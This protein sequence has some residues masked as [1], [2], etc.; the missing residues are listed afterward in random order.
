VIAGVLLAAGSGRRYGRPKALVDTGGGPWVLRALDAMALCDSLLVVVGA[1]ADEVIALLPDGVS[2]VRNADHGGG[3]GSSLRVGL[4]A[5]PQAAD[6]ALVMLVDLPDVGAPVIDR[7]LG[8]ARA[9]DELP[10]LLYRAAYRGEPGHPVLLGRTHF[11]GI[12]RTAAGDRG[13]RD[14]LAAHDVVLIE[15]GDLAG[16]AD[17]DRPDPDPRHDYHR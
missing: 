10:G 12:G 7:V 5:V 13:A 9:A 14:Y 4:A 16:G 3:M 8:F 2:W 6:A 15:C 17:V 11:S 1:N